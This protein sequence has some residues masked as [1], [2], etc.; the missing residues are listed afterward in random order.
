MFSLFYCLLPLFA[1]TSPTLSKNYELFK[2][3]PPNLFLSGIKAGNP[4]RPSC[5]LGQPIRKQDLPHIAH[6][7][8][9]RCNN[10]YYN[11][12]HNVVTMCHEL[13]VFRMLIF[14]NRHMLPWYQESAASKS[15]EERQITLLS[16]VA[17]AD[18]LIISSARVRPFSTRPCSPLHKLHPRILSAFPLF[19]KFSLKSCVIYMVFL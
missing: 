7:Y 11:A 18:F 2:T 12:S 1:T 9:Q 17:A 13:D 16:S 19:E 14:I 6:G 3:A 15:R 4:E 10:V 5:P 8:C